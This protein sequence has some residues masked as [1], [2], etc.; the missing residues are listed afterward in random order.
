V[1]PTVLLEIT[2]L[3]PSHLHSA[4]FQLN[5]FN[6][7]PRSIVCHV[8]CD[9]FT[10]FS[11]CKSPFNQLGC[12]KQVIVFRTDEWQAQLQIPELVLGIQN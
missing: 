3:V 7:L 4:G 9:D 2:M 11:E 1:I 5:D 8:V 6:G 10:I 12:L